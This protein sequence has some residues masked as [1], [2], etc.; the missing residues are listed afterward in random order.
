MTITKSKL[1]LIKEREKKLQV[2][3]AA[4]VAERKAKIGVLA[5]K[6]KLIEES[7][8]KREQNRLPQSPR[9]EAARKLGNFR[10]AGNVVGERVQLGL[11]GARIDLAE[12][13]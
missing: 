4:A 11:T 6:F 2:E 5:E 3:Y 7:D 13:S 12:H 1:A 8:E 10:P 9:P